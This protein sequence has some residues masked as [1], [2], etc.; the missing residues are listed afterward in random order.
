MVQNWN[1]NPSKIDE[2]TTSTW[3]GILATDL[4]TIL[5]D[6]SGFG[7]QVGRENRAKIDQ[8]RQRKNDEKM[9]ATKMPKNVA[10]RGHFNKFD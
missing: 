6:F 9:N 10:T 4:L 1:K 3:D 5:I 2:K 7:R 8:K